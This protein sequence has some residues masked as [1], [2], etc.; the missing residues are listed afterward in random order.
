MPTVLTKARWAEGS[1]DWNGIGRGPVK[2]ALVTLTVADTDS[3][4][5]TAAALGFGVVYA[6][7]PTV[8]VSES[9]LP[10]L[11]VWVKVIP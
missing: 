5:V 11:M 3:G 9:G 7:E 10:P 6:I 2:R 8:M 4:A 1:T